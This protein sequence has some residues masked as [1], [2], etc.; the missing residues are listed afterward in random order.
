MWH[1]AVQYIVTRVL[2]CATLW[3]LWEHVPFI[4]WYPKYDKKCNSLPKS[5]TWEHM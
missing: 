2:G 4:C 5:V 1:C 3:R